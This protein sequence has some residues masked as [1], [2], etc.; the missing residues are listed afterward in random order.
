M[1]HLS[2][3]RPEFALFPPSILPGRFVEKKNADIFIRIFLPERNCKK[4]GNYLQFIIECYTANIK[5][6]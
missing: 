3:L 6:M 4:S 1:G 2:S 5:V